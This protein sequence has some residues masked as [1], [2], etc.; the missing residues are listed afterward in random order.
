[1]VILYCNYKVPVNACRNTATKKPFIW[2]FWFWENRSSVQSCGWAFGSS[3]LNGCKF[4]IVPGMICG[5]WSLRTPWRHLKR[6]FIATTTKIKNPV[7]KLNVWPLRQL[8]TFLSGYLE[9]Y[10]TLPAAVHTIVHICPGHDIRWLPPWL[11]NGISRQVTKNFFYPLR[12]GHT[13]NLKVLN[14]W[15]VLQ[16]EMKAIS[17]WSGL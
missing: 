4:F 10:R 13:S 12:F 17:C 1:M 7:K 6:A 8:R 5:K 9:Q 14:R 11:V 16:N 3:V 2:W 15:M